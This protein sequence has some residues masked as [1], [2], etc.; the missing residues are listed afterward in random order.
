MLIVR[1]LNRKTLTS[2]VRTKPRGS[3]V[4]TKPLALRMSLCACK[5]SILWNICKYFDHSKLSD[6]FSHWI[7]LFSRIGRSTNLWANLGMV[8]V[9]KVPAQ[10]WD[11]SV[12]LQLITGDTRWYNETC[13]QAD[14]IYILQSTWSWTCWSQNLLLS[15]IICFGYRSHCIT[16]NHLWLVAGKYFH[17]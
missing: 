8:K 1:T 2:F 5:A 9:W 7:S 13:G 14:D 3:V 4:F 6:Y 12:N 16:C 15:R 11:E 17:L 10:S